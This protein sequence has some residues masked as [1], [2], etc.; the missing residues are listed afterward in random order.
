MFGKHIRCHVLPRSFII[1]VVASSVADLPT[2]SALL[3]RSPP[4]SS[5]GRVVIVIIII[6]PSSSGRRNNNSN[7][8][9]YHSLMN[10]TQCSAGLAG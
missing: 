10:D 3:R 6:A 1:P 7:T 9:E 8:Q 4:S 2:S 5:F